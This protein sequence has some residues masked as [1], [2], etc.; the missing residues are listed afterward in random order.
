M[1]K[2]YLILDKGEHY[3][4]VMTYCGNLWG[5]YNHPSGV[6][7]QGWNMKMLDKVYK[8]YAGVYQC[9]RRREVTHIHD[10]INELCIEIAFEGEW[11]DVE[12]IKDKFEKGKYPTKTNFK[13]MNKLWA[14]YG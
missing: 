9:S 3:N 11:F 8:K 14:M 1:P 7:K 10:K 12:D 2:Y 4:E 13:Y 5:S 6:R